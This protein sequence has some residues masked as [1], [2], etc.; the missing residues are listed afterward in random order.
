MNTAMTNELQRLTKVVTDSFEDAESERYRAV[1]QSLVRHLHAFVAD[2]RLTEEEWGVAIDVLTRTGQISDASRQ[3]FVLLSDVLGVSMATVAVNEPDEPDATEATVLGPFFVTGAPAIPLGGD[4]SGGATGQ[5]CYVSGAVRDVV[6]DPVPGAR[7][8]VWESDQDGFY[9]VQY[10][11]ARVAGRG[12]LFT[13]E[14]GGY[15]FWSVRPAPYPIPHDGPVGELLTAAG[16]GPMRPAHIHFMVSAPGFHT[17][18]THIFVDGGDYLRNDAV[19]GVKES[20]IKTFV[21][22][23]PGLAPEGRQMDAPWSWVRFDI[24]LVSSFDT[25]ATPANRSA[26]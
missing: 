2:V 6:G 10:E 17:L 19:F 12:H 24:V 23:P 26:A 11:G 18:T 4:I 9:D 14:S 13:D 1:M 8:E 21:E 20:L 3:E 22:E 7:I 25:P 5:P 15:R 16:R